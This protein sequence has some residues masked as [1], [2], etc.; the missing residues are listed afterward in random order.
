MGSY[1]SRVFWPEP[2]DW[3]TR[4]EESSDSNQNAEEEEEEELT[5]PPSSKDKEEAGSDQGSLEALVPTTRYVNRSLPFNVLDAGSLDA[6]NMARA[7][8]ELDEGNSTLLRVTL[9]GKRGARR[10]PRR[11]PLLRDPRDMGLE[12]RALMYEDGL[13]SLGSAGELCARYPGYFWNLVFF[14]QKDAESLFRF[15]REELQ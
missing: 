4:D 1:V 6:Q 5:P 13:R 10:M 3:D 12:L 14:Y 7:V 15:M 9:P 11:W 2:S 8:L